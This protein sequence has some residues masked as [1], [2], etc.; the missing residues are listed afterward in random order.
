MLKE[1]LKSF[2]HLIW[3]P[4]RVRDARM[5]A[6]CGIEAIIVAAATII[7]FFLRFHMDTA[8]QELSEFWWMV[9]L[10]V[11]VRVALFWLFGLYSWVWYYMGVREVLC[12]A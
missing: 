12:L 11:L 7:A 8:G 4:S 9:P 1:F 2:L 5:Y 6:L 10:A 3:P